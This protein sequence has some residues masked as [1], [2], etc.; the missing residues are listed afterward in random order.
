MKRLYLQ[1]V[2]FMGPALKVYLERLTNLRTLTLQKC[3]ILG[4]GNLK[5]FSSLKSLEKLVL[6]DI[7]QIEDTLILINS[8]RGL[9]KLTVDSE[10][11]ESY[12]EC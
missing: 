8:C 3:K 6:I 4:F 11:I 7:S 10:S 5:A 2:E 12:F 1:G 9:K